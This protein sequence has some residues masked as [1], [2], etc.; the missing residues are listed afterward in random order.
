MGDG[1]TR[2]RQAANGEYLAW[3]FNVRIQANKSLDEVARWSLPTVLQLTNNSDTPISV[4]LEIRR[5]FSASQECSCDPYNQAFSNSPIDGG[6]F[7]QGSNSLVS[8]NDS[9]Y[10]NLST[11]AKQLDFPKEWHGVWKMQFNINAG[12]K[13]TLTQGERRNRNDSWPLP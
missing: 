5:D 10:V 7:I 6:W 12:G 3:T 8:V 2:I 9:G 4:Q 1:W 13:V 11:S